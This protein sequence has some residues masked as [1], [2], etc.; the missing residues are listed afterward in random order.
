[1]GEEG[2]VDPIRRVRIRPSGKAVMAENSPSGQ[3]PA[4]PTGGPARPPKV[5][6]WM[7]AYTFG[8]L[9]IAVALIGLLW[10]VGLGGYP[11]LLFGALLSMPVAYFVLQPVRDKF[12][13]ALAARSLARRAAKE[14]LRARLSGP[15][16]D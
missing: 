8:R 6:P 5:L 16:T 7:L 12:T 15:A 9:A 4:S 11:A 14:E 10:A 3:I 1:M 2:V 13:E